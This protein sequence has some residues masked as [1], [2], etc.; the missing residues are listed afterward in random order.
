MNP[1]EVSPISVRLSED[2]LVSLRDLYSDTRERENPVAL[3]TELTQLVRILPQ[4]AANLKGKYELDKA[5]DRGGAGIVLRVVDVNLSELLKTRERKVYRALKV[6]RPIEDREKLLNALIAK[7]FNT[8]AA[9]THSNVIKLYYA[10]SIVDGDLSRPFY[11][12]DFI[13]DAITPAKFLRRPEATTKDLLYLLRDIFVGVNFLFSQNIAHNDLKPSNVLLGGGRAIISDLGSAVNLTNED[14]LTTIT[15]TAEYAHP[16]KRRLAS[17][18]TDPNRLKRTLPTKDLKITW[19]LYSLGL[20]ILELLDNFA[21]SHPDGAIS[22]YQYP[23]LPLMA[24]R[25]LIAHIP[26]RFI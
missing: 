26:T 25:L 23:Y 5:I 14:D 21:S 12:M 22:P 8:L 7:E 1:Q 2:L 16:D 15:F 17:L 11:V 6:A 24:P 3:Q 19:D 20:T 13:E 9:L 4:I 18:S 10:D